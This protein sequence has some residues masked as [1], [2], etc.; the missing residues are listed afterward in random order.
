[1]MFSIRDFNV[2]NKR[3]LVRVDF[4]VPMSGRKIADNTR[5]KESLPTIKYLLNKK[6]QVIL[7]SHLGRPEG[8]KNA[9]YSLKPIAQE[10]EK[11][12][13]KKILFIQN[14]L[15]AQSSVR[16]MKSKDIIL[17]ENLRFHK[18][19]EQ[20]D[21]AFAK[22]LASYADVYI[23]DAFS[24][25]HRSHA[26]I[27]AITRY[28][29]SA[30]G[31]LL[32]KETKEL[33]KIKYPKHPFICILGG[34][35][36]SKK[37]ETIE[38]F[39]RKADKILIG[40]AIAASFIKAQGKSIGKTE[41]D[42]LKFATQILKKYKKKIILPIDLVT[43][44]KISYAAKST[45]FDSNNITKNSIITD[46]GKETVKSFTKELSRA[47]TIF[48]HG[49]LGIFEFPQ[50]AKGSTAIARSIARQKAVKIAGGGETGE[51]IHNLHLQRGFTYIS[52]SGS[53]ALD[54]IADKTLPGLKALGKNYHK[55]KR[56][57]Q[58]SP[59]HSG[60]R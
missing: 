48:W 26:S 29:P 45:T 32:E 1:M 38:H 43:A 51:I 33:S 10:L 8:K 50:W 59:A 53:A 13:H 54:F 39:A 23:N 22:R 18:E 58:L 21:H 25:S 27:D 46:M 14:Y 52:T 41:A 42:E 35:K 9:K 40:G 7:I 4:N 49:P 34:R 37:N 44:T 57:V 36:V 28:L 20:N 30:A 60:H 6:A 15:K 11:L 24:V 31:F 12:L 5:I 2:K 56:S 55:F 16:K 47:K 17:L 3:V 19:E